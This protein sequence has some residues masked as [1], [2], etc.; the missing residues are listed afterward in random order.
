MNLMTDIDV[1]G[2]TFIFKL[3]PDMRA[4]MIMD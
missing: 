1:D 4:Y 2:D 3:M